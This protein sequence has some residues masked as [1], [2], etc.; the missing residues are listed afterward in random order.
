[1]HAYIDR[2]AWD[3]AALADFLVALGDAADR[4]LEEWSRLWLQTA[5]LNTIG[6]RWSTDDGHVASMELFQAAPQGHDTL[7]PHATT[8]GLV[9]A[10]A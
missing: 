3:N 7:R 9:G 5:S 2:Y 10:D 6:V 1:L 4:P 8:I